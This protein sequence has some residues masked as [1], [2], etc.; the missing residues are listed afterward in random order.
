MRVL[1]CISI[2]VLLSCGIAVQAEPL[3]I[4]SGTDRATPVAVVPFEGAAVFPEGL[5]K[6]IGQDLF[7]S[8]IFSPLPEASMVTKPTQLEQVVYA[9][10]QALGVEYVVLGKVVPMGAQLQ[11]R[12]TLV[13]VSTQQVIH[14]GGV[15]GTPAQVRDI[16]HYIADQIFAKL[17]GMQ[18]AFSTKLLYVTAHRKSVKDVSYRL[19]R[20]D[21]DGARATT[22]LQSSEPIL[23]PSF[24]PDG[25]RIA[26]VSFEKRRPRIFIQQI[27]TGK[28]QQVT[29]FEGLN[30]APAW[31]PDGQQLAFVLSK[32]GNPEI[33]VMDLG[34]RQLRRITQHMGIDTEPFWGQKSRS[35]YF[36]SDRGGQP[37]IYRARL[38][39]G[40]VER[41]TFQGNYNA[42]PKV[43]ADENMLVMVHRQE[44]HSVFQVAAQDLQRGT[45]R[46]LSQTSLDESPT[47]APNGAMLTYATRQQGRGVLMLVSTN[48]RVKV[49]LPVTQGEVREPAWSPFLN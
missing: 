10:W 44:G 35:L 39:G 19:V 6:I 46:V 12:Y 25:K 16:A 4:T 27:D 2:W 23:S 22:L 40:A 36:T 3:M 1:L 47:V 13:N 45:I 9:D 38:A 31:S 7:H 33:Y 17:T 28:R 49:P 30:N 24:A 8:G 37:Q 5:A 11:V 20:A 32:D 43:S 18:G 41:V 15:G 42:N 14:S 34:S 48:G 26:Y 21:Y 29:D